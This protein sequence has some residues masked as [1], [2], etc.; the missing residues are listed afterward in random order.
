MNRIETRIIV[1]VTDRLS[2]ARNSEAKNELIEE[3][4][5]NLYQRYQDLT[6]EG[7]PEEEALSQAMESLGD[8]NELLAYLWSIDGESD[9]A[10]KSSAGADRERTSERA[11]QTDGEAA[12]NRKKTTFFGRDLESGIEDVVNAAVSAARTAAGFARDAARDMSEQFKEKYP[13]GFNWQFRSGQSGAAEVVKFPQESVCSLDVRLISADVEVCLTKDP[14]ASVEVEGDP[15]YIVTELREDGVLSVKQ[16]NTASSSVLFSRGV[17]I[18]PDVKI[19]LPEKL[20]DAVTL[21]TVSGD[22]EVG[23]G[24]QCQTV[25][26]QTQSGDMQLENAHSST[27]R[28]HSNSG[29]IRGSRLQGDV[30]AETKS[31]DV[32]LDGCLGCLSAS[33]IS[34]DVEFAGSCTGLDCTSTSGDVRMDLKTLPEQTK[35][36]SISGD[37]TAYVPRETG[38]R[39]SYHTTSGDFSTNLSLT[40]A[41][42]GK[43]GELTYL[44][45]ENRLI[46]LSSVSGDL[47]VAAR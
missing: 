43:R 29:D 18:A 30:Y 14:D 13:D 38:F 10:E 24:L 33:S 25:V 1:M 23:G 17:M 32:E 6:A 28:F 46:R 19:R 15:E 31:G 8:T 9:A 35:L 44:E 16:E 11:E 2:A 22:I 7:M 45:E 21:A 42:R 40:G 36:S 47:K 39:L 3:L 12:Y 27:T 41:Y 34:G 37:C 26:L 4:S 5:E 20:W